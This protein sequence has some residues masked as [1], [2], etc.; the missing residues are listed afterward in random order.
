MT[1]N[2][3]VG[4]ALMRR[5]TS[6]RVSE[7]VLLGL[8]GFVHE[9][10]IGEAMLTDGALRGLVGRGYHNIWYSQDILEI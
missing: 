1:F 6:P 8:R 5:V 2:R 4:E 9:L 10:V 3:M 7:L